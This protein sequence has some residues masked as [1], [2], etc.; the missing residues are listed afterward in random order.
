[1]GS[2]SGTGTTTRLDWKYVS[3]AYPALPAT[4]PA[5][6]VRVDA[7]GPTY[8]TSI[9]TWCGNGPTQAAL[10]YSKVALT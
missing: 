6:V 10:S 3:G 8:P 1:M 9:P 2:G 4:K 7:I 5:N